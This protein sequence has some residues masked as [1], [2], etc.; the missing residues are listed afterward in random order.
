MPVHHLPP[1]DCFARLGDDV[2]YVDVRSPEEF[3]M[4]HPEGSLNIPFAFLGPMGMAAN[5]SFVA[6]IR[7]HFAPG[8]TIVLGCKSGGRSGMAAE[9]LAANGFTGDL[10][11]VLGGYHGGPSP[12]G[13]IAG[14]LEEGLPTSTDA[15]GKAWDDL[16]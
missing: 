1:Q 11:N 4:G 6:A 2:A 8:D 5:P 15:D 7:K 12:R 13:P 9:M 14:W 16:K 10:I 3:D